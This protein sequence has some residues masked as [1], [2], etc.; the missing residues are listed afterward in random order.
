MVG[1]SSVDRIP[2]AEPVT[3]NCPRCGNRFS[4]MAGLKWIT[5]HCTGGHSCRVEELLEPGS[6]D[7]ESRLR[8]LLRD[9]EQKGGYLKNV[10]E[11]ARLY[12]YPEVADT[13]QRE[14]ALLESRIRLLRDLL[15]D[16]P[17]PPPAD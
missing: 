9:M 1:M 13:F 4:L 16:E 6:P 14:A 17:A 3:L 8:Q 5:L 2:S 15:P 7:L 11:D 12:G 10:A